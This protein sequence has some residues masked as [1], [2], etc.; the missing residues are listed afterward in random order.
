VT[1]KS[2]L[3]RGRSKSLKMALFDRSHSHI[4]YCSIDRIRVS[5]CHCNYSFIIYRFWVIWRWT[6]SSPWN[7][8]YGSLKSLKMAPFD[9]PY[10]TFYSSAIVCIAL[11]CT[12]FELFDIVIMALSCII[13]WDIGRKSRCFHTLCIRCPAPP[14]REQN[15]IYLYALVNLKPK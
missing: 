11:F 10:T 15:K 7:F 1:S 8:G 6:I 4:F 3:L 5:V 9:R 12:I 13:K 2:G 14:W